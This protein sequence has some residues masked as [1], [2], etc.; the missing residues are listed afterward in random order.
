MTTATIDIL[1]LSGA[2][3]R[4]SFNTGLLRV[5]QA[6]APAGVAIEIHDY[7][8]LP[9]YDSDVEEAGFPA[10]AERL[11]QRI[12]RAD[13]L[14]IATPEYNFSVPGV[15]KNALDWA[16]RPYGQSAFAGKP[17]AILGGGGGLGAARAQAHLRD[18]AHGLEMQVV[19]RPEVFVAN[20]WDKL[21]PDGTL[22]DPVAR[23]LI[24]QLVENLAALA[25]GRKHPAR[26]AA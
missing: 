18:I 10:A 19:S 1:G 8:D 11:K 7:G 13:G 12:R 6:V 21:G 24:R 16:S 3:R 2:L 9:L 5:A 17:L 22:A 4:G 26:Q 15:L 25:R 14:L 23:D 20:V